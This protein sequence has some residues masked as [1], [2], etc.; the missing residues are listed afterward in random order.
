MKH[1]SLLR[2]NFSVIWV[3]C[4]LSVSVPP[5]DPNAPK[6]EGSTITPTVG[7]QLIVSKKNNIVHTPIDYLVTI[8]IRIVIYEH[9]TQNVTLKMCMLC[10]CV[11]RLKIRR[12]FIKRSLQYLCNGNPYTWK[13]LRF[14]SKWGPG[15]LDLFSKSLRTF[16]DGKSV[17]VQ[18]MAWCHQTAR[19]YR[20]QHWPS[21]LTPYNIPRNQRVNFSPLT[22]DQSHIPLGPKIAISF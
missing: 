20:D 10:Q 13:V 19:H 2:V 5:P 14:I 17:L 21:S 7:E 6:P 8:C 16:F 22:C 3:M 11:T 15:D 1:C 4:F 12:T 9:V 18:V